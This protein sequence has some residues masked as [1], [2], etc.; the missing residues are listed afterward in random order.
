MESLICDEYKS[1]LVYLPSTDGELCSFNTRETKIKRENSYSD[2]F[3]IIWLG[4]QVSLKYVEKIL[5]HLEKAG[6]ILRNIEKKLVL[7]VV[8][9]AP[10]V[11][12][13]RDLVIKNTKWTREAAWKSLKQAHVGIMPLEINSFTK[14]KGG[15]KLIQYLSI[16]LPVIATKVGI[17]EMIVD[18]TVGYLTIGLDDT[19]WTDA[20]VEMSSDLDVWKKMS[21]KVQERYNERYSFSSNLE[22]WELLTNEERKEMY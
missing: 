2:E 17:N 18:E 16:G 14:G 5:P 8:C 19:K 12:K 6:R 10:L 20:I 15:F 3:R 4:T 9:D 22:K 1:K 21:E 11:S 7:E 13:G